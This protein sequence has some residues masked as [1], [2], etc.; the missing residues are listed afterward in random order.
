MSGQQ[1]PPLKTDLAMAGG[2]PAVDGID[3]LDGPAISAPSSS[4]PADEDYCRNLIAQN[5]EDLA[6]NLAFIGASDRLKAL[7]LYALAIELRRIPAAVSEAGLGEIRLQWWRDALDEIISGR[8]PRKHPVVQTLA[9]AG[10]IT[11]ATRPLIETGI[12][13][14]ARLLYPDP[15]ADVEDLSAFFAGAEGWLGR[16]LGPAADPAEIEQASAAYCLARWGGGLNERTGQTTLDIHGVLKAFRS[17]PARRLT[18]NIA[19]IAFLGLLDG[20]VRRGGEARWP[21]MKRLG[22]FQVVLRGWV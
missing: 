3:H 11:P 9:N 15:F 2:T 1:N 22:L 14:R 17:K 21:L 8:A 10:V 20:Y 12:D 16:V 5:D 4:L 6:L 18:G 19:P 7:A 13:A